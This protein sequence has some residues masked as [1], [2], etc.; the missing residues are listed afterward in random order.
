MK[1][2]SGI[3]HHFDPPASPAVPLVVDLDGTL[4]RSDLLFES[5]LNL[6]RNCPVRFIRLPLWI[7]HGKARL[8]AELAK[9]ST[10]DVSVLPYR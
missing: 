3:P 10:V 4:I 9:A 5:G 2:D 8:K 1:M 6:L 7:R